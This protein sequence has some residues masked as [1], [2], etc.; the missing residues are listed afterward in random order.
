MVSDPAV[1]TILSVSEVRTN[2]LP[3]VTGE[4]IAE[5]VA[6]R[7]AEEAAVEEGVE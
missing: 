1:P 6:S 3:A 4:V 5:T 2:L 7:E